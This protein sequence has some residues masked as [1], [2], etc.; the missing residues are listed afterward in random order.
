MAKINSKN[1]GNTAE[2]EL[3]KIFEERFDGKKF[4]RVPNSGAMFGAS[5]RTLAEGVEGVIANTFVG[6]IIVPTNFRYSIESKFYKD[7]SFWDLFNESSNL[8]QWFKQSESDA[9]FSNRKPMIV[10]KFNHR[11][12]ICFVKEKRKGYIFEHMGWYCYWLDDFLKLKDNVFF[13]EEKKE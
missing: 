1:K 13:E 2:R 7:I 8:H 12:R 3:C 11:G 4:M 6:D 5:N 10:A 9:E